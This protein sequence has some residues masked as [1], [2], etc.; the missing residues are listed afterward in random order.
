MANGANQH[1]NKDFFEVKR[2]VAYDGLLGFISAWSTAALLEGRCEI[3]DL[4]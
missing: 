4:L 2:L 1:S 3:G